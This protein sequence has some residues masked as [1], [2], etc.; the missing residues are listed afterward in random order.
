MRWSY[1]IILDYERKIKH[2]SISLEDFA[3]LIDIDSINTWN[4]FKSKYQ[5][6]FYAIRAKYLGRK[7]DIDL[8]NKLNNLRNRITVVASE[9]N[10]FNEKFKILYDMADGKL[11]DVNQRIV[12]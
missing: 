6:L 10:D 3:S 4:D 11:R 9:K 7:A 1:Y 8:K 12:A 5:N 2:F